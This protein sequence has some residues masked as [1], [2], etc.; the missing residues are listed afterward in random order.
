MSLTEF[1]MMYSGLSFP[2]FYEN[3][4]TSITKVNFI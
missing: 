2:D 1:R 3:M 4:F